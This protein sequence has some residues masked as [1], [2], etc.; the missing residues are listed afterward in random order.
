MRL[1]YRL[2]VPLFAI[3][4]AAL[5]LAPAQPAG[6]HDRSR[7]VASVTDVQF[8]D[9]PTEACPGAIFRVDFALVSQR[10]KPIARGMNCVE[11]LV[12]CEPFFVGCRQ[13]V[14]LT[15]T[16]TFASHGTLTAAM[17][18]REAFLSDTVVFERGKGKITGG[19]GDFVGATGTVRT[20][21]TVEFTDAGAVADMR[22][23]I[24]LRDRGEGE[25][26][27]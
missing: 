2:R 11:S 3:A 18:I 21:G 7:I 13:T 15:V 9:G 1:L 23:V 26:H 19:T 17:T 5:T 16:L 12:G 4:L 24:R 27:G 8:F 22:M 20:R 6:G 10:G 25:E 14:R